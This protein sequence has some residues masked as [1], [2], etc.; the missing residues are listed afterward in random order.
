[1]PAPVEMVGVD[2]RFGESGTPDE[3]MAMFGLDKE[4]IVEA[5]RKAI[6]RK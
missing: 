1:M 4:H 3:L 2:D 5:C 6:S